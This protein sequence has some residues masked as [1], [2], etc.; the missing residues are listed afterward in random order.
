M[1]IA[2]DDIWPGRRV[3][4]RHKPR[5][6]YGY[7]LRIQAVVRERDWPRVT[8]EVNAA[9]GRGGVRKKLVRVLASSLDDISVMDSISNSRREGGEG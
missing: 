4:W 7:V 3:V 6:G 8:I 9:D 5:G 1:S 2:R